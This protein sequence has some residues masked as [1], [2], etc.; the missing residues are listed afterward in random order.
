[1]TALTAV[2]RLCPGALVTANA[3]DAD[4]RDDA[5]RSAGRQAV[6][7]RP[8]DGVDDDGVGQR[9]GLRDSPTPSAAASTGSRRISP[10]PRKQLGLRDSTLGDPAG[11]DDAD[12]VQ[13]RSV[14]ERVRPRDRDAQRAHRARDREVGG[15][16]RVLVRRPE[17]ACRTISSTTTRCCRAAG[18]DYLGAIGFKTGFTNR[19]Q[20]TLVAAATRN[21]RTLIAVILGVPDAG[22][23]E[24]ASLLDAGF[25]MPP[26]ADGHRR[27]ACRPVAVSRCADRAADQAAFA[28]LGSTRQRRTHTDG[29]STVPAR[30]P[31]ARLAA[32]RGRR[33]AHSRGPRR[34]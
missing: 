14:H 23:Q 18:A 5:H 19:S 16:A 26:D 8:D 12:V 32:A 17:R 1:M 3:Q 13:G 15:D 31:R 9:R 4:G 7:V 25:A 20:H 24:A 30:G 27:D 21:G 29:R 2:E 34:P 10:R 22:Y 11:L 33:P 6:A 28:K